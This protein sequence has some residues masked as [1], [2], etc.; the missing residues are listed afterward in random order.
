MTEANPKNNG[1]LTDTQLDRYS[2]QLLLPNVDIQGQQR[3]KSAHVVVVGL[4]GLGSPIVGYLAAA[5]IGTLTVIDHDTVERSNLQRQTLYREAQIGL[6]KSAAAAQ[7]VASI[8]SEVSVVACHERLHKDNASRLLL[9]ADVVV[10]GTD[11]LESR[12]AANDACQALGI[13]LVN[14][15]AIG[16]SGQLTSFDF[17]TTQSPCLRCLYPHEAEVQLSCSEAGVLGPTVG[18][19]G[20]LMAMEVLKIVLKIGQPLYGQLLNWDALNSDFQRFAFQPVATC[21]CQTRKDAP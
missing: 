7:A 8:N 11:N 13:A 9:A 20:S 16:L 19:I 3:L 2:R 4:G 21:T 6:N 15:S 1:E 12:M 18:V 17:K 5:G 10:I 14:G